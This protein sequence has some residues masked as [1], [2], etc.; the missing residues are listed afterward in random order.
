MVDRLTVQKMSDHEEGGTFIAKPPNNSGSP[1]RQRHRGRMP[2]TIDN[3]S[4]NLQFNNQRRYLLQ[5]TSIHICVFRLSIISS[6]LNTPF[7]HNFSYPT[8]DY[9]Q[10]VSRRTSLCTGALAHKSAMALRHRTNGS[11]LGERTSSKITIDEELY[12]ILFA[13]E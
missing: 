12:D 13:F 8:Y 2:A 1:S 10:N 3:D 9:W 5:T 11:E 4:Q 6:R 7:G